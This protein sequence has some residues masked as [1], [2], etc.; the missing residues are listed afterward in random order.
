MLTSCEW[1]NVRADGIGSVRSASGGPVGG[2]WNIMTV[3]AGTYAVELRRWPAESGLALD[4]P[5]PVFEAEAGTVDAGVAL[6]IA[7]A[8]LARGRPFSAVF[9]PGAPAPQPLRRMPPWRLV[10]PLGPFVERSRETVGFDRMKGPRIGPQSAHVLA[11][12]G[13]PFGG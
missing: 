10:S 3:R 11:G 8:C 7:A 5:A 9:L 4:A 13:R 12:H 6:P 1:E 2:P